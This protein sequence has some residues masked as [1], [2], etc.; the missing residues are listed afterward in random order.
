[1]PGFEKQG[2]DLHCTPITMGDSLQTVIDRYSRTRDTTFVISHIFLP[3]QE[4][5]PTLPTMQR[6]H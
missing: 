4:L 2:T 1:M 6:S 3:S 5:A